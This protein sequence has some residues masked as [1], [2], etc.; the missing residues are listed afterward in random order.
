MSIEKTRQM[1]SMRLSEHAPHGEF[2]CSWTE[3]PRTTRISLGIVRAILRESPGYQ[4]IVMEC[5]C[6]MSDY[7]WNRIMEEYLT[8]PLRSKD[9]VEWIREMDMLRAFRDD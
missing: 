2:L 4:E 1:L 9:E 7:D 6:S 3:M 5:F 8:E